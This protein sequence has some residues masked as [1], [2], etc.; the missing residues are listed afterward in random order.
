M[1]I[2]PPISIS[3]SIYCENIANNIFPFN[4]IHWWNIATDISFQFHLPWEY[5]HQC[6]FSIPSIVEILPPISRFKSINCGNLATNISFQI[7]LPGEYCHQHMFSIPSSVGTLPLIS[8][9]NYINFGKKFHRYLFSIPSNVGK[10]LPILLLKLTI[11][12]QYIFS[13]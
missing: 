7:H 13:T 1:G 6:L 11:L 3:N 8:L 12:S 4:S 10:L 2:L 5:W 9:F